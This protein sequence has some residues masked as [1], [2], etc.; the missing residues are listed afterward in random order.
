MKPPPFTYLRPSSL[1]EALSLLS[2]RENAKI[3]AGGQSL[4]AMLNLR[5]LFPDCLIDINRVGELSG[6]EVSDEKI[7]IGAM[8]RQRAV[9]TSRELTGRAPI[10]AEALKLVG[11]RQTRNRGTLGGSLCHLDPSA[12]LP[13]LALLYEASVHV[14][15][16]SGS[17]S[18]AISDFI[19]GYM[20]PG[21]RPDELVT[22]VEFPMWSRNHGY[23]FVE[24]AR[25]HGDFAIASAGCLVELASNGVIDRIALAVGG[26]GEV[27]M[28]LG[29]AEN[30][31]IRQNGDRA[32]FAAA[33]DTCLE[34]HAVSDVH[35]GA[36]YRRNVAAAM[37]RR[38][39]AAAYERARAHD[40]A[41]A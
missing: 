8:T 9:E 10:F 3:L 18:I 19:A 14:A 36:D 6:L 20:T 39:L 24:Y 22:A 12:E 27:P 16:E 29:R 2:T 7:R 30:M 23:A 40:R 1:G 34:L 31:L 37:V 21:I 32:A 33:A 25:R 28:R 15:A 26:V 4:V 41:A 13:T 17:R 11:H 35:A 38:S 5:Y